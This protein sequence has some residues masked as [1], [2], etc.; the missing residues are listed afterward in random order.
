MVKNSF[1]KK[2]T[3][4]CS[5]LTAN[6]KISLICTHQLPLSIE[7]MNEFYVGTEVARGFV[8]RK[9]EHFSTV[10]PQPIGLAGT[11]DK[12][13]MAELG[14]IAGSESRAYY[15]S[16]NLLSPCLWGPTVDM[17]RDPRWGRTEEGYGEDVCLAGEMTRAYTEAMAGDNGEYLKSIPTLKHFCANN[18]ERDRDRCNSDIPLRLKYEYYYAAFM[19]AVKYG[20]AK[21]VMT[22]YNEINGIPALCNPDL[23]DILKKKW[24]LWFAVTD[25]CDFSY[26]ITAHRY[27][28]N[29]AEVLAESLKSGCDVFNDSVTL[30]HKAAEIALEKGLLTMEELDR[31]VC[32]V[33]YARLKLGQLSSDCPYN[34]ITL[35]VLNDKKSAETNLRAAKEQMVLLKNNGILPLS[36]KTGKIAVVGAI[37]KENFRDW[38]TGYFRDA[39]SPYEGIRR[40]FS[41][42]TVLCDDLWD[43]VAVKASN[44]RYLSAHD[45]ST[46]LAD[47][48][49]ISENCLFKLL[50]W[51]EGWKN[52]LSVKYGRYAAYKDG[53]LKLNNS[54]IYDWFTNETFNLHH[55]DR[56]NY[57]IE[58][59]L[60]HRRLIHEE[61]GRLS[62]LDN[63]PVLPEN[64]FT[65]ETVSSGIERGR[66]LAAE[67]DAVICCVGNNP[68]QSAKECHDRT[69]LELGQQEDMVREIFSINKNT[70]MAII[71]SYPYSVNY[72][73]ENLPA[74]LYSTHTGAT[75]G[76]ALAETISG[77]NSPAGRLAMTWYKSILDLPDIMEY[78]IEKSGMTYMYFRGTPLFPFGYGLSYAEFEYRN[79]NI[80]A[81]TDGSLSAS[82]SV[83]NVSDTDSDEVV[84]LYFTMKNSCVSRPLKKLCAFERVHIKAHEE[85]TVNLTVRADILQIYD[86]RR[87]DFI[88]EDGLYTFMAGS[89]S[90][91]LPL[92]AELKINGEALAM[93]KKIFSACTCDRS[94][95]IKIAWSRRLKQHYIHVDG[96]SGTAVY[97]G[98]DLNCVTA[99]KIKVSS[100]YDDRLLYVN[101]GG[102]SCK[103]DI[104]PSLSC[105]DFKEYTIPVDNCNTD[106]ITITMGGG[107]SLLDIETIT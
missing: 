92:C 23:E 20:G 97:G 10:F 1:A 45:D 67:C 16:D 69:T 57:I 3:E 40:E 7:G 76:T 61:N 50:D 93:R 48:H 27:G 86:L 75:L 34:E 64:K 56:D 36:R 83:A 62:F 46:I 104:S 82:V 84:Q 51:G 12:A 17:E 102:K 55:V 91:N 81:N 53:I 33:L 95:E 66:K 24:G 73:A 42:S 78:D 35:D 101:I 65:V 70:I 98:I 80:S 41:D 21:S 29:H 103:I 44:G 79:L 37:A 90:T 59:F 15:N 4:L 94:C 11:F 52:L 77:K 85:I 106:V 54:Y 60:L 88:T 25:G 39:V 89:S 18:N 71:S 105:D 26:T 49:E 6:D 32:N 58:D 43:I 31:A 107:V 22:S 28:S 100:V 47:S 38:Y 13:L 96:W 99:L 63:I 87:E 8:G 5:R 2:A 72:S 30:I 74:I 68:V 9:P 19:Y 14:E